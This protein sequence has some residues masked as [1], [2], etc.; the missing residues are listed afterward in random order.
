MGGES[1]GEEEESCLSEGGGSDGAPTRSANPGG[2]NRGLDGSDLG[3]EGTD[4]KRAD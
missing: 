1:G 3:G 4:H 2:D